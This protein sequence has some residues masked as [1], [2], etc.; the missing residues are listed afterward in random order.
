MA[1]YS[2]A[3]AVF[4]FDPTKIPSPELLPVTKLWGRT[5]IISKA[6]YIQ[7]IVPEILGSYN[8]LLRY[9]YPLPKIDLVAIPD[10]PVSAI[11]SWGLVLFR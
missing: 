5:D 7:S 3:F 4:G 1:T 8:E 2:V 9:K 10:F 6:T 11:S